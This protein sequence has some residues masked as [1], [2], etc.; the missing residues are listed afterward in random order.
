M[1][2]FYSLAMAHAVL[3]IDDSMIARMAI[4]NFLSTTG[5]SLHEA[6]CGEDGLALL[7]G[8]LEPSI[9][10]LDLTMPGIGGAETLRQIRARRPALPVVVITA[11]V[12]AQTLEELGTLGVSGVIRKPADKVTVL[13]W[14]GK[15]TAQ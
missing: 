3:I 5:A 8:G 12:Q 7:D 6:P 9:V 10:Y 15:A 2:G 1:T 13:T 4:K 14:Y 11:D